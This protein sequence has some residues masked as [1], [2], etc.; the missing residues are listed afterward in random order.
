ME[1]V[2]N[3]LFVHGLD[4]ALQ[5]LRGKLAAINRLPLSD[6]VISA[7]YRGDYAEDAFVPAGKISR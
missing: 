3:M 1:N 5:C 6:F 4:A 7:E 2:L